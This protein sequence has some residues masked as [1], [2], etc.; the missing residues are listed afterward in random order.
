M[1]SLSSSTLASGGAQQAQPQHCTLPPATPTAVDAVLTYLNTSDAAWQAAATAAV[2]S[3]TQPS[4]RGEALLAIASVLH[5]APW[6][7][8]IW[9][10][11]MDQRFDL[12]LFA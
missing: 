3:V 2:G 7:R 6:V 1:S 8:R 4:S 12:G 11:S 10:V 5:L 9:V